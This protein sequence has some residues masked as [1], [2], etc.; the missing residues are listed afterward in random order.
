MLLGI[1]SDTHGHVPAGVHEA[2]RNVDYIIHAGDIGGP[3][4]LWELEG[5]APVFAVLGNNDW[6]D[7]GS[8]VR[9]EIHTFLG[10][11]RIF[12]SHY[13]QD[14]VA[15]AQSERYAL[16]IHGHTHV[17][18]DTMIGSARVINPGAVAHPREGSASQ[19]ATMRIEDGVLGVVHAHLL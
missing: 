6:Q 7:Y 19:C 15:A 8:S 14:A 3:A 5:I 9:N 17:P 18:R 1:I 13:P 11:A 4:V 10:G 12:I 2:F 16:C